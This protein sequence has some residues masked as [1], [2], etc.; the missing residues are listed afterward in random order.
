MTRDKLTMHVFEQTDLMSLILEHLTS[1]QNV[2]HNMEDLMG[3]ASFSLVNKTCRVAVRQRFSP[4]EVC[5][6]RYADLR[7]R[8]LCMEDEQRWRRMLSSRL[9]AECDFASATKSS[10]TGMYPFDV[11]DHKLVIFVVNEHKRP[12]FVGFRDLKPTP[13]PLSDS[14]AE[15]GAV[16]LCVQNKLSFDETM[17][18]LEYVKLWPEFCHDL[19]IL[20]YPEASGRVSAQGRVSVFIE[21]SDGAVTCIMN[22][23]CSVDSCYFDEGRAYSF[24]GSDDGSMLEEYVPQPFCEADFK[25]DYEPATYLP[26]ANSP[27][28]NCGERHAI[29]TRFLQHVTCIEEFIRGISPSTKLWNERTMRSRYDQIAVGSDANPSFETSCGAFYVSE[30]CI[31]PI[32]AMSHPL[33]PAS[34]QAKWLLTE[35]KRLPWS[36]QN[37]R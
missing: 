6:E 10:E 13:S 4:E 23:N 34:I 16:R 15:D 11:A 19:G 9:C 1:T 26:H 8:F 30:V 17:K 12:I 32:R 22:Q 37:Q 2:P 28:C 7:F 31:Y 25:F 33:F 36:K 21:R 5:R 29:A 14:L 3:I 24:D 27:R 35:L 20:K 18:E